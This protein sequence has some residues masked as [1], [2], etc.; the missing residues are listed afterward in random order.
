VSHLLPAALITIVCVLGVI[1]GREQR[2]RRRL[3]S[4]PRTP[5]GSLGEGLVRVR[6]YA[7]AAGEGLLSPGSGQRCLAY[8]ICVSDRSE[9]VVVA[10]LHRCAPFWIED[11]TGRARVRAEPNVI[12][13]PWTGTLRPRRAPG[14]LVEVLR[15]QGIRLTTILADQRR[16]VF[17]EAMVA[18]GDEISVLGYASVDVDLAEPPTGP[19]QLPTSTLL[20]DGGQGSPLL[21]AGRDCLPVDYAGDE[22]P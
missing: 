13:F 10:Q 8:S 1:F 3:R 15:A 20:R 2:L 18:D 19:R 16:F 9:D 5:I 17:Q 12:V 4:R 6:G 14:R 11:D 22:D 7:R 21:I